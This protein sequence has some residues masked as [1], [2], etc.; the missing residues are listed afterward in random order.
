MIPELSTDD[1]TTLATSY[2]LSGGQIENIARKHAINSVL[3]GEQ[4]QPLTTLLRDCANE[5]LSNT[6]TRN[7]IGF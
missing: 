5:K 2:D 6:P 1:A 4:V 3:Y 7:K